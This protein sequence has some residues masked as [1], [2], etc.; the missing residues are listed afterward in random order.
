MPETTVGIVLATAALAAWTIIMYLAEATTIAIGMQNKSVSQA[1]A[2]LPGGDLP[3][4]IERVR[5]NYLNLVE[6][7]ILFYAVVATGL[8]VGAVDQTQVTLAWA[9]F[10]VRVAHTVWHV[11]INN[12]PVRFTLFTISVGLLVAMWTRLVLGVLGGG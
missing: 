5:R 11:L 1:Q 12:V 6:M 4:R 10:G 3:D 7:P 9:Y 8:A 2:A